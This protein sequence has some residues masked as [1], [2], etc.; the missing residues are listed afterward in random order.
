MPASFKQAST[1]GSL[2]WSSVKPPKLQLPSATVSGSRRNTAIRQGEPSFTPGGISVSAGKSS[3]FSMAS[4]SCRGPS[5]RFPS[6]RLSGSSCFETRRLACARAGGPSVK[7]ILS[8]H[9][10]LCGSPLRQEN[11]PVR[12]GSHEFHLGFFQISGNGGA[13]PPSQLF[14]VD[15]PRRPAK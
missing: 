8:H 10:P 4:N 7:V 3:S 1:V 13:A 2:R 5:G 6:T 14:T 9:M 11:Y 15:T 12:A